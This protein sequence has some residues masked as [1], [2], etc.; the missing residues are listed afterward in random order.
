MGRAMK[1]KN[2]F[3]CRKKPFLMRA[4]AFSLVFCIWE[5]VSAQEVIIPP[6]PPTNNLVINFE[7][8][9]DF[10]KFSTQAATNLSTNIQDLQK[11]LTELSE[12][13]TADNRKTLNK[14]GGT[15][16]N[17]PGLGNDLST[18]ISSI[19]A[20]KMNES[21]N[22]VS[23][24]LPKIAGD[25]MEGELSLSKSMGPGQDQMKS[26][27]PGD[28][29][30]MT[31]VQDKSLSMVK[32]GTISKPYMAAQGNLGGTPIKMM[33]MNNNM[34]ALNSN[35]TSIISTY[36]NLLSLSAQ[37]PSSIMNTPNL[38]QQVGAFDGFALSQFGGLSRIGETFGK[39][40][41][42]YE[43][44]SANG[45]VKSI[46]NPDGVANGA[47]ANFNNG[48]G[49]LSSQASSISSAAG[50]TLGNGGHPKPLYEYDPTQVKTQ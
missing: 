26:L 24:A 38:T 21:M 19:K 3:C 23:D 8:M 30:S 13:D 34:S 2:G 29:N 46:S 10:Q 27:T 45:G 25:F 42:S 1:H 14:F 16:A 6:K 5:P 20:D 33:L 36:R 11:N 39:I 44:L 7:T 43:I 40:N 15:Y 37:T 12:L 48:L 28:N 31:S 17:L 49:R 47:L 9:G 22:A 18:A 32:D 35:V 4:A 50:S 41:A